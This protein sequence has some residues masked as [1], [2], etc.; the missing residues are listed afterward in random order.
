MIFVP[1]K[2]CSLKKV[3]AGLICDLPKKYDLPLPTS[4]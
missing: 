4:V 2:Q 3:G 1:K